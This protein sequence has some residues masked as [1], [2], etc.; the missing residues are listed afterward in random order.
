M[1]KSRLILF[2]LFVP[3][4]LNGQSEY[5]YCESDSFDDYL[6][7]IPSFWKHVVSGFNELQSDSLSTETIKEKKMSLLE[8]LG[9]WG[10]N[11]IHLTH[12]I[13]EEQ[14]NEYDSIV[15]YYL[16][17]INYS[18]RQ[19]KRY[20]E[21]GLDDSDFMQICIQVSKYKPAPKA[22]V[23]LNNFETF[24]KKDFCSNLPDEGDIETYHFYEG[25]VLQSDM[26]KYQ[27]SFTKKQKKRLEELLKLFDEKKREWEQ[28]RREKTKDPQL[29]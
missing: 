21:D 24:V 29:G 2:L 6:K 13:T 14:K 26:E 28:K 9:K 8:D 7:N 22:D 16:S 1:R 17:S 25:R 20:L 12:Q 11:Y 4:L 18:S 3:F 10:Y 19:L 23:F 27:S 5:N 15:G